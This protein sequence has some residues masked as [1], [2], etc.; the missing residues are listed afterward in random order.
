MRPRIYQLLLTLSIIATISTAYVPSQ[1]QLDF[2]IKYLKMLQGNW[3]HEEDNR[4]T[5]SIVGKTFTFKYSGVKL[6][7]DE[8]YLIKFTDS[9]PE[10]SG[11]KSEFLILTNK[12]DTLNYEILGLNNKTLSLM[13][14]PSG[15]RHLYKRKIK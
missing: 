10:Y 1:P 2:R 4:A 7:D 9:L 11:E 8:K 15:M 14:F 3:L 12:T 13:H 5:I 6:T